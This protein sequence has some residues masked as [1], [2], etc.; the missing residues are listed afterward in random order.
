MAANLA[1][2]QN[3]ETADTFDFATFPVRTTD[4]IDS[5]ISVMAGPFS[6]ASVQSMSNLFSVIYSV[7]EPST[8]AMMIIGFAGMALAGYRA[9]RRGVAAKA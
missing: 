2:G 6:T 3:K 4:S 9:S 5:E 1:V 8:W 7:P